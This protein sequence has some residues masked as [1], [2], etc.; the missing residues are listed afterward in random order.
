L[1][2]ESPEEEGTQGSVASDHQTSSEDEDDNSIFRYTRGNFDPKIHEFDNSETQIQ[3]EFGVDEQTTPYEIL[4]KFLTQDIMQE[5]V[6]QTNLFAIQVKQINPT[7]FSK[8]KSVSEQE[9]WRF[10]SVCMMMGIVKKPSISDNW[11]VDEMM[12]TP[13]FGK[14]MSRNR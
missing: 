8:W 11:C 9:M 6:N 5:M 7:A 14:I 10:L 13:S 12:A 1:D 4:Q 3:P 2:R